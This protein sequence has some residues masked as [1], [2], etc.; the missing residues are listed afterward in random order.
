[1][2]NTDM[3]GN[4][5]NENET[6]TESASANKEGG[7]G[8]SIDSNQK[9]FK[10]PLG[11]AKKSK[12]KAIDMDE[13]ERRMKEAYD[14]IKQSQN[15]DPPKTTLCTAYGQLVTQRLETLSELQRTIVM[16]EIDNLFFSTTMRFHKS[17]YNVS[18]PENSVAKVYATPA[19]GQERIGIYVPQNSFTDIRYR[20]VGG[21]REKFFK[22]EDKLVGDF[23][24]LFIRTRTGN[25]D[26]LNRERKDKYILEVRATATRRDGKQKITLETETSVIVTV[27]DTND[28]SPLFYPTVYN[29][30]CF[31]K[32]LL[33]IKVSLKS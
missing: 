16:H 12:R 5:S 8:K 10:A 7:I 23:C 24:F 31:T 2:E 18:I 30:T 15:T 32:I 1:M 29:T 33:F 6:T 17:S 28:L 4:D 22:A 9:H 20:I 25:S 21:A 14:I 19:P 13:T 26:V 3:R 27:L 11:G